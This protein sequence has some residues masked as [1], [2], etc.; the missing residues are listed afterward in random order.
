MKQILVLL[1]ALSACFGMAISEEA[2]IP[3]KAS[4]M[5][6]KWMLNGSIRAVRFELKPNGTFEYNGYGSQSKGRWN[7]EGAQVRLRWTEIDAAP[8]DAKK[9]TSLVSLEAGALKVGKFE[10][11]KDAVPAKKTFLK[12][13]DI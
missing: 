10:Y 8:V 2:V 4:S 12:H 7:V 6:G 5:T 3:L 11:R 13:V 9:V 1:A